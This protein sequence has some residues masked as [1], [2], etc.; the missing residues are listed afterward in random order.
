M[1]RN[2][3]L[4]CYH[5]INIWVRI[6]SVLLSIY[7]FRTTSKTKQNKTIQNKTKQSKAKQSKTKQNKTTPRETK[8]SYTTLITNHVRRQNIRNNASP[9]EIVI[10][11]I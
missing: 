7:Y 1:A 11:S 4:H 9:V 10:C 3:L 2:I 8:M 6:N 5:T